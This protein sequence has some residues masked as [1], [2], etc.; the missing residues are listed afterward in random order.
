[1]LTRALDVRATDLDQCLEK[2]ATS[3]G[4]RQQLDLNYPDLM[5]DISAGAACPALRSADANQGIKIKEDEKS[6]PKLDGITLRFNKDEECE[7]KEI[8]RKDIV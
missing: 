3:M 6:C 4:D 5:R 8:K 1:M 7:V 2:F